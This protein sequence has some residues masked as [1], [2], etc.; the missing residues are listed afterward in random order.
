MEYAGGGELFNRVAAPPRYHLLESEARVFF[1]ELLAGVEYCHNIVR[2]AIIA[3]NR[4]I[5]LSRKCHAG[6]PVIA[7]DLGSCLAKEQCP[8]L[9][10]IRTMGG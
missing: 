6:A 8:V 2:A 4:N 5:V 1:R 3:K 7:F 10:W 9:A